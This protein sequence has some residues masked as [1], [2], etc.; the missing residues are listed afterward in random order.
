[1]VVTVQK[2]MISNF[3][4]YIILNLNLTGVT[5]QFVDLSF[6]PASKITTCLFLHQP[7]VANEKFCSI[8]YGVPGKACAMFS[9][10]S[11]K[12]SSDKVYLGFPEA[13]HLQS[14]LKECCFIATASNG[15]FTISVEGSMFTTPGTLSLYLVQ[16]WCKK[17]FLNRGP[18][19]HVHICANLAV[20]QMLIYKLS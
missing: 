19:N 5:N 12:S 1:M 3:H 14:H 11:S 4:L 17:M 8:V 16:Q 10:Q 2:V 13:N 18:S 20:K 15:T 6:D 7:K 9:H